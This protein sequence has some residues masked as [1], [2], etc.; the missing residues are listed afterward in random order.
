MCMSKRLCVV[1]SVR[2]LE[3]ERERKRER[4]RSVTES[5]DTFCTVEIPPGGKETRE[6]EMASTGLF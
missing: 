2:V 3:R 1:D 4:E 6:N 5:C